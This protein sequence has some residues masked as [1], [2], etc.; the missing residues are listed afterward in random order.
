MQYKIVNLI[1][2]LLK[3]YFWEK[4]K[5]KNSKTCYLYNIFVK[6]NI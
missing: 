2:Y 5:A 6:L 1:I 4:L 3:F